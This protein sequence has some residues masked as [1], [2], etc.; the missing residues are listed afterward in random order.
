MPILLSDRA[1]SKPPP[2]ANCRDGTNFNVLPNF[3]PSLS[4]LPR[5]LPGLNTDVIELCSAIDAI[6]KT[7]TANSKAK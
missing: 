2:S 4:D 6:A 1:R 7:K 5:S 3:S